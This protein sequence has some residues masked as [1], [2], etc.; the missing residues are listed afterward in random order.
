MAFNYANSERT[1]DKQPVSATTKPVSKPNMVPNSTGGFVFQLTPLKALERFLILGSESPTYYA[2]AR[3]LTESNCTNAKKAIQDTPSAVLDMICDISKTGRAPKQGPTLFVLSLFF[4][5]ADPHWKYQASLR[6]GEII[7]TFT[8]L[9]TFMNFLTQ[10]HSV[11]RPIRRIINKWY[12]EKDASAVYY[13]YAK[14]GNRE[15]WKHKDILALAHVKPTTEGLAVLFNHMFGDAD[16]DALSAV[17]QQHKLDTALRS[18]KTEK[19]ILNILDSGDAQ[20]EQVP[21]LWLKSAKVWEK[22]LPSMGITALLRSMGRI[23]STGL[24]SGG[25]TNALKLTVS[26]LTNL[27]AIRKG[28]VHPIQ[29]LAAYLTYK[30][31]RAAKGDTSWPVNAHIV[32]ALENMYFMSFKAIEPTNLNYYIGVDTSGSMG[33]GTIAGIPGLT[34]KIASACLAAERV[35][36][37][38]WTEVAGFSSRLVDLKMHKND[39]LADSIQKVG[40][41]DVACTNPGLLIE[42]AIKRGLPVDVFMMITDNEVN[43]GSHPFMLLKKYRQTMKRDAKL[44]VVGMTATNFTLADPSDGGMLDIVGFDTSAP[45]AIRDFSLNGI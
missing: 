19:E 15:G 1:V 10:F 9:A 32:G 11:S 25:M 3:D 14:Y 27:D 36:T 8:H 37:E 6:A 29:V 31:G 7:R 34:P 22:L 33:C 39:T 2:T 44:V 18:A 5:Y 21:T 35:K 20:W 16:D 23:S 26:N 45:A 13:Q 42:D 40:R 17:F 30:N 4:K 43:H 41:G 12:T 38:P 24:F 28:R